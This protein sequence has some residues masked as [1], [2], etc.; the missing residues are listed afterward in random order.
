M[1]NKLCSVSFEKSLAASDIDMLQIQE[2][3]AEKR[4]AEAIKSALEYI[5]RSLTALR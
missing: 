5:S 4:Q 3:K 1:L 2:I